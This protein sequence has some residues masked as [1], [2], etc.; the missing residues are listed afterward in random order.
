MNLQ[1][2][3]FPDAHGGSAHPKEP[4]M[5]VC[6]ASIVLAY[7]RD[8]EGAALLTHTA[9]IQAM[10]ETL[11]AKVQEAVDGRLRGKCCYSLSS[12]EQLVCAFATTTACVADALHSAPDAAQPKPVSPPTGLKHIMEGVIRVVRAWPSL[13]LSRICGL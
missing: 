2:L 9:P 1:V 10:M 13:G 5:A 7:C 8:H 12:L 11:L 3:Q 4:S 6:A